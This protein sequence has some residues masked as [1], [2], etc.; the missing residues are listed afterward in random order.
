V[1]LRTEIIHD[2]EA[3][4]YHPTN[5][6]WRRGARRRGRRACRACAAWGIG[7]WDHSMILARALDLTRFRAIA[8]SRPGYLGTPP[9]A[10]RSPQEQADLYA[11]TLD[12]L[13]VEEEGVIEAGVRSS[14]VAICLASRD[15][16]PIWR[17]CQR[18]L[19][20]NVSALQVQ[21]HHRQLRKIRFEVGGTCFE[22]FNR[23]GN[24]QSLTTSPEPTARFSPS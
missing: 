1:V 24:S 12:A 5:G 23:R 22:T 18:H 15:R 7:G 20:R 16:G 9:A 11:A 21:P 2:C 8:L 19:T 17:R 4:S 14:N 13:G 10:G 6:P 3:C